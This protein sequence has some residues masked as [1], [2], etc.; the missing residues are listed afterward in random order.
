MYNIP[1]TKEKSDIV[2]HSLPFVPTLMQFYDLV[3]NQVVHSLPCLM[4]FCDHIR[5]CRMLSYIAFRA[6]CNFTTRRQFY[7]Y[8]RIYSLYTVFRM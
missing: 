6:L 7:K 3:F 2:S 4:Q 5:P 8:D 1:Q